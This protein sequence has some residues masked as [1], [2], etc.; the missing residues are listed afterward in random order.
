MNYDEY[1]WRKF[2]TEARKPAKKPKM[3]TESKL[4]RELDEDEYSVIQD[5]I[6]EM[7]PEDL[8]FNELFEGK[9]R[10]I[11]DF[12]AFDETS[13]MGKFAKTLQDQGYAVDW[14]KGLVSETPFRPEP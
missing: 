12:Q 6:D 8:A 1:G 4:L 9:T 3:Y 11:I 10:L 5:A 2:L 13:D 7:E 14:E